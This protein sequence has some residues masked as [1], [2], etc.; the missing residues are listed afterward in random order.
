MKK[1]RK[2]G[3]PKIGKTNKLHRSIRL[4]ADDILRIKLE[5]G[6]IQQWI[7]EMIEEKNEREYD[8]HP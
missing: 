8:R 6:S 5:F 3:R 2:L 1:K 4:E 7:D